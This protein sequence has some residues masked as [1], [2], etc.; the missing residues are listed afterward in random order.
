MSPGEQRIFQH[1]GVRYT[2][3]LLETDP[4]KGNAEFSL[5]GKPLQ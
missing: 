5:V 3:V 1:E 4:E 2:L